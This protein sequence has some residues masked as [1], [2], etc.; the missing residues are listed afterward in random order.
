MTEPVVVTNSHIYLPVSFNK[1]FLKVIMDLFLQWPFFVMVMGG[2]LS[3]V[4][5][6]TGL[7]RTSAKPTAAPKKG[8]CKYEALRLL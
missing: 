3:V 4:L 6:F 8:L 7:T 5:N 2:V 1:C